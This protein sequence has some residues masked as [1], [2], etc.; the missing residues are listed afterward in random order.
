M[1]VRFSA[2]LKQHTGFLLLYL[3]ILIAAFIAMA[4]FSKDDLFLLI[5]SY[6]NEAF[7][8]F[9]IAYTWVGD[10]LTMILVALGFL[11]VKYRYALLTILAYGYTAL[12][13]QIA[14]RLIN[15]PRPVKYFEEIG[16]IRIIQGLDMHH[17][18]SFPSGHSITAFALATTLA[19]LMPV[20]KKKYAWILVLLAALA[21]F[22]R[23]YLSQH[24]ILDIVVGSIIGVFLTFHLIWLLLNSEWYHAEKL[25]G[26]LL[27]NKK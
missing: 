10:G 24:F 1:R 13:G 25:E 26:R 17:W 27:G 7:D 9:F 15:E 18:H 6:Y 21:A 8:L 14:K 20:Q 16:E 5:N 3:L 2:L 12:F 4:A 19:F 23:V 11:F 22:S